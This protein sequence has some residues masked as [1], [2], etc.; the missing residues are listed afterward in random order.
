MHTAKEGIWLCQL[1]KELFIFEQPNTPLYCNNQAMCK[2]TTTDN[3]HTRMKHINIH[4]HFIC[5]AI[6]NGTFQFQYCPTEDMITD[7][8][9][10]ALP[11]W[12]V[13]NFVSALGL[14]ST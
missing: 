8:L 2:L 13:K 14:C 10:K 5:Q 3:F 12:K 1:I 4:Y 9:T 11:Q 7:I 6:E